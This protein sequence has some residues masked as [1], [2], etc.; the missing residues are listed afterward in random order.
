MAAAG[1]RLQT[2]GRPA[3]RFAAGVAVIAVTFAG[4]AALGLGGDSSG[5][6]GSTVPG[7]PTVALA[8]VDADDAGR[9]AAPEVR[10]SQ[11]T[12]RLVESTSAPAAIVDNGRGR[13][14]PAVGPLA[15]TAGLDDVAATADV[16]K[17]DTDTGMAPVR[18]NVLSSRS[19]VI[20]SSVT[21]YVDQDVPGAP[22]GGPDGPD[23]AANDSDG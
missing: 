5:R 12:S 14:D 9:D 23:A 18:D 15:A 16:G 1:G 4:G 6:D 8:P 19:A 17:Y 3:R 21:G 2:L 11:R 20:E 7:A 10:P 13:A 22:T